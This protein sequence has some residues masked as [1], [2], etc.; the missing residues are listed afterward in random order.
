MYGPNIT[1]WEFNTFFMNKHVEKNIEYQILKGWVG[2]R[3]SYNPQNPSL[4]VFWVVNELVSYRHNAAES[5]LHVVNKYD[6]LILSSLILLLD[7][8]LDYY[9][10]KCLAQNHIITGFNNTQMLVNVLM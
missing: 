2:G 4:T 5:F 8:C 6:Y 9:V 10:Y 3:A 7:C 1:G